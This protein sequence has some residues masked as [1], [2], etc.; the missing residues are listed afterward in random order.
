M[1]LTVCTALGTALLLVA[2]QANSTGRVAIKPSVRPATPSASP[3][4]VATLPPRTDASPSP[5]ASSLPASSDP[6]AT[7]SPSPSPSSSP[8]ASESPAVSPS[9]TPTPVNLAAWTVQVLAGADAGFANGNL[10]DTRFN[11]PNGLAAQGKKVWVTDTD[12]HRVRLLNLTEGT[13]LTVAGSGAPGANNGTGEAAQLNG[14]LGIDVDADGTLFV[15][16]TGNH[17]IRRILPSGEV[18]Q[19]A[20]GTEGFLDG[21]GGFARFARPFALCLMGTEGLLVVDSG[22]D[23]L[24]QVR[25]DRA[26]VTLP[27]L[28][29]RGLADG[30]LSQSQFSVPSDVAAMGNQ[31]YAVADFGNKALRV[32]DLASQTVETW[33]G[34]SRLVGPTGVAVDAQGAVWV[35]DADGHKVLRVRGKDQVDVT[36]GGNAPGATEGAA[37][38][39]SFNGPSDLV[40]LDDGRI[41]VADA[42]N[43]RLRVITP[44]P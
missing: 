3:A 24:R 16:D 12:N 38:I 8:S 31:R 39:A 44:A 13:S 42:G 43:H 23:R 29:T 26:V 35:A 25:T 1:R 2:C 5:S 19:W 20:G 33:L 6:A 28:G 15:A 30:N 34:P 17:Q 10:A 14:P 18:E 4:S 7:T 11:N 37:T 22:N 36:I 40:V 9:P 41:V 27:G 32:V 21:Q